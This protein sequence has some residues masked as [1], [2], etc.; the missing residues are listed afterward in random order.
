MKTFF[1]WL[2]VF[3]LLF[4]G[5]SVFTHLGRTANPTRIVIS[6][7]D[8]YYMKEAWPKIASRLKPYT[9]RRYTEYFVLSNKTKISQDWEKKLDL[10]RFSQT[11]L[12]LEE[13]PITDLVN[14]K[15]YPEL[16]KADRILIFTTNPEAKGLTAD[17]KVELIRL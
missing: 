17:A 6:F 2:I 14:S 13:F 12:F 1:S 11:R 4:G 15:K 7:D 8:S 9:G 3:I 16:Q 10:G 5:L